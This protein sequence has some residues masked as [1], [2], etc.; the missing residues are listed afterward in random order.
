MY[1]LRGGGGVCVSVVGRSISL[2]QELAMGTGQQ[3]L[4]ERDYLELSQE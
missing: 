1:G 4:L 3:S 2:Y